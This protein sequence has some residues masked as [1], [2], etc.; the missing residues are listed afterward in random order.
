MTLSLVHFR[1]H[2]ISLRDGPLDY[3]QM[4]NG[5]FS[6]ACINPQSPNTHIQIPLSDHDTFPLRI[7]WENL[8]KDQSFVINLVILISFALDDAF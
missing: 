3:F 7:S 5:G 1:A 8:K 4:S 6:H 2:L